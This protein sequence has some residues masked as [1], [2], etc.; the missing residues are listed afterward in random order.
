M[1]RVKLTLHTKRHLRQLIGNK[2][3]P[4]VTYGLK[5]WI[6]DQ[7]GQFMSLIWYQPCYCGYLRTE[8]VTMLC[9]VPGA[10]WP[11]S[12]VQWKLCGTIVSRNIEIG[13]FRVIM[14]IMTWLLGHCLRSTLGLRANNYVKTAPSSRSGFD[15][16]IQ[17]PRVLHRQCPSS[18]GHYPLSITCCMQKALMYILH[19]Q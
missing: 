5:A 10:G 18:P 11:R 2:P 3:K 17:S 16:I 13:E 8:G 6:S 19:I 7:A 9:I 4:C 15:C 12:Q 1:W 14:G